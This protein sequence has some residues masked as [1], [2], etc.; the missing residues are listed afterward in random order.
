MRHYSTKNPVHNPR[1]HP[2]IFC[3]DLWCSSLPPYLPFVGLPTGLYTSTV[4]VLF[5]T[6]ATRTV[7]EANLSWMSRSNRTS[8]FRTPQMGSSLRRS[9]SIW[10]ERK[11]NGFSMSFPV[12]FRP[13]THSLALGR[14]ENNGAL[15]MDNV[16]TGKFEH[17][18]QLGDSRVSVRWVNKVRH[19]LCVGR[20]AATDPRH[21][22]T[23]VGFFY[24][25]IRGPYQ[26]YIIKRSF[27]L[28]SYLLCNLNRT[29]IKCNIFRT[30]ASCIAPGGYVIFCIWF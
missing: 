27:P 23:L 24:N 8:S 7:V 14:A 28:P 22:K 15:K 20:T 10:R 2:S 18:V 4:P 26:D 6:W 25:N 1:L 11:R 12:F 17:W 16:V 21:V 9:Q 29:N 13:L 19:D 30:N 5:E 3:R